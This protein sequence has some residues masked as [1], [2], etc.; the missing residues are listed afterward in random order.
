MDALPNTLLWPVAES[1][2]AVLAE[3][4]FYVKGGSRMLDPQQQKPPTLEEPLAGGYCVGNPDACIRVIEEFEE[5]GVDEIMP[6]FQAGHA[7]HQEVMNSIRLFG[8]YVIPHF[9]EKEQRAKGTARP[10]A[11]DN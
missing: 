2:P 1:S 11:A 5:M 6:I 4:Q 8:K 10:S 3:Y 9:K 7:T